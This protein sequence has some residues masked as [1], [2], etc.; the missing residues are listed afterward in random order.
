MLKNEKQDRG[1]SKKT[2]AEQGTRETVNTSDSGFYY[3]ITIGSWKGVVCNRLSKM[4]HCVVITKGTLA[5]GLVRLFRD[6]M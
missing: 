3:K 1:I 2:K 5:E 4:T 6:N